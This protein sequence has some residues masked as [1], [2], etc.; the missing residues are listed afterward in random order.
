MAEQ[1]SPTFIE[2]GTNMLKGS[3]LCGNIQY[4]LDA[5]LGKIGICHCQRCRKASGSAYGVNAT[6]NAAGF[7]LTAGTDS[8]AQFAAPTGVTRSFC[9]NCGSQL[10]STRD[11]LPGALRLRL[12][13]LD[14]PITDR[15]ELHFY[16]ASKAEW[17]EINDSLPQYPERA[18]DPAAL[19]P[20]R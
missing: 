13:S 10:Y 3:C 6:V 16:T 2:K 20:G 9:R 12:G 7:R 14:T 1:D 19:L 18:L 4:E 17:D 15:P 8:L 5:P 11:T